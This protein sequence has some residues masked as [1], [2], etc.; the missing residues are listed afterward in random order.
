[1]SVK[2]VKSSRDRYYVNSHKFYNNIYGEWVAPKE[3]TEEEKKAF[4]KHLKA[5]I[6]NIKFI[7]L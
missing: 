1:M 4:K 7:N 3:A 6:D 2:I 5:E